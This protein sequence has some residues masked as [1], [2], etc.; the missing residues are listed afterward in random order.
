M[1]VDLHESDAGVQPSNPRVFS[2]VA[3]ADNGITPS[4]DVAPDGR[5]VALVAPSAMPEQPATNVTVVVDLFA[6][7]HRGAAN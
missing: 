4:F 2:D 7:L 1:V 6:A 3:L 5:V